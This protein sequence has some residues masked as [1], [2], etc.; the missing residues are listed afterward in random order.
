MD[1][2][3]D[4]I[5]LKMHGLKHA[6]HTLNVKHLGTMTTVEQEMDKLCEAA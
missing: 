3:M 4:E 2:F 1:T 6:R 5:E